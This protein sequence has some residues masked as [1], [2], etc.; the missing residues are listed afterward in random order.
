MAVAPLSHHFFSLSQCS[1][2]FL[3]ADENSTII[4]VVCVLMCDRNVCFTRK[5]SLNKNY[6]LNSSNTKPNK[7]KHK[8]TIDVRIFMFSGNSYKFKVGSKA[9]ALSWYRYL[10]GAAKTRLE[11]RVSHCEL[12]MI[13][14]IFLCPM[15]VREKTETRGVCWFF[16]FFSFF[17]L[18]VVNQSAFVNF[19]FHRI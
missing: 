16:L 11:Y 4:R 6:R 12:L 17:V 19:R 18:L 9:N 2:N 14:L 3:L 13:Y 1:G 7:K 15:I 5:H 10:Q 8:L